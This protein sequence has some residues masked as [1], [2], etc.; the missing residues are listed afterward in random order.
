MSECNFVEPLKSWVLSGGVMFEDMVKNVNVSLPEGLGTMPF[1]K[2]LLEQV[3][4]ELNQLLTSPLPVEFAKRYRVIRI[5]E[6]HVFAVPPDFS[7]VFYSSYNVTPIASLVKFAGL[8]TGCVNPNNSLLVVPYTFQRSILYIAP[9]NQ[10]T[11]LL[12]ILGFISGGE[13]VS[14]TRVMRFIADK[15]KNGTMKFND[16]KRLIGTSRFI[17]YIIYFNPQGITS[18]PFPEFLDELTRVVLA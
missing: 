1:G 4:T 13:P 18:T 17:R 8:N 7:S 10:T 14:L 2:V 6:V 16:F 3:S 5:P 11:A 15:S 9:F 12:G